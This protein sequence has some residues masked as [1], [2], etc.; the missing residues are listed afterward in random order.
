MEA[1]NGAWGLIQTAVLVGLIVVLAAVLI[2]YYLDRQSDAER[3][4]ALANMRQWGIALNLHLIEHDNQL[5]SLGS[6]DV[7]AEQKDAWYNSLPLYIGLPSLA[8]Y[9]EGERPR[10][11]DD[12]IWISP[13]AEKV[14]NIPDTIHYFDYGM[15]RYL[16]PQKDVRS[17]KI[18]ELDY[19]GGVIFLAPVGHFDP[20]SSEESVICRFGPGGDSPEGEAPILFC[21][22]HA[23]YIKKQDLVSDAAL[24]AKSA[25]N[26]L[27]WFKE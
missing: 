24:E 3:T 5:P 25:E 21:D 16:Q 6:D 11:G 9:A 22:G 10:P 8:D 7:S 20:F 12:S 17:F 14:S 15:N 23:R 26:G 2:P 27:S 13:A 1:R 19:P 18:N 4:K